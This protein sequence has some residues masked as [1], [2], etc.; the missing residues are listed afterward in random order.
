MS[1][2]LVRAFAIDDYQAAVE[3]W[4]RIE[5]LGLNE[6]DTLEAISTFLERN[7][8]FSAV[9]IDSEGDLV[10]TVLCGHNGRA[11]SIQH[12]AV[13]EGYRRR[14]LA[15][16]LLEYAFARLAEARI[17]RC[18]VFVYNDNNQG[19]SFWLKSGWAD[20][21]TWRVLQK[22]VPASVAQERTESGGRDGA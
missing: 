20:P 16:R 4:S 12:L 17:P 19:N 9:A 8:D 1:Q 18:N 2:I 10:G 11:G 5:G 14:G 13:A 22:H 3:F 15:R 21:T 7:P 6:S